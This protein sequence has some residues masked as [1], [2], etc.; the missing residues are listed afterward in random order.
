MKKLT[1]SDAAYSDHFGVSVAISGDT[2][3]VG[4]HWNACAAGDQCGSAY[5]FRRDEGGPD[6]WG[7]TRKLTPSDASS[8]DQFGGSVSI[9]GDAAI[10]GARL[11]NNPTGNEGSAYVFYS[12]PGDIPTVSEW[13]LILMSLLVVTAGTLV[14]TR[15]RPVR[16]AAV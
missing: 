1:A 3:I 14:C 5:V 2:A 9:S 8:Y 7:E 15:R 13:G 4:A 12:S 6:N 10:V 16:R 11:D